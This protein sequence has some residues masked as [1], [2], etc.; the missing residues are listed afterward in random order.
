MTVMKIRP[1]ATDYHMNTY[2]SRTE[3][4]VAALLEVVVPPPPG[5]GWVYEPGGDVGPLAIGW[6]PDFFVWGCFADEVEWSFYM[7]V[8]PTDEA[9]EK[10]SDKL[11][12]SFFQEKYNYEGTIPYVMLSTQFLGT[13]SPTIYTFG[14]GKLEW[15]MR[16][17][18]HRMFFNRRKEWLEGIAH[19]KKCG[20]D[21]PAPAAEWV[22]IRQA[23]E[24]CKIY[25][26]GYT[27]EEHTCDNCGGYKNCAY[28][29]CY[30]CRGM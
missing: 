3:A 11:Q 30:N 22:E 27:D 28:D 8:K 24:W 5:G 16:S 13:G 9:L 20:V 26:T 21:V 17:I 10:V 4:H 23:I 2:R 6:L 19:V 12:S 1:R 25:H 14:L 29:T 7:E 18:I 15:R